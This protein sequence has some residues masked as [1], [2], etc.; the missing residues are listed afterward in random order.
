MTIVGLP[1]AR[2]HRPPRV[3]GV[4]VPQADS[5]LLIE[6][7]ERTCLAHR[8]SVLD[9]CTGSGVA[10]IAAAELGA[11]RVTAFDICSRA[12]RCARD[13]ARA[14]GV[15]I[16]VRQGPWDD[17][18]RYA[19]FDL[20]VANPPYVPSPRHGGPV[21]SAGGPEWSWNGGADGRL[22]LDPLCHSA[23]ALLGKGGSLLL[24]QSALAGVGQSLVALRAVGLT[25]QVAAVRHIPFGPVLSAHAGWLESTGQVPYGCRVEQLVVIRADK[26]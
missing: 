20:V 3:D 16:A 25:A 26:P 4:Y 5:Q 24:V 12:V 1:A 6:T 18:L 9:L 8:A 11:D 23:A 19:P 13:N 14:A 10:A 7:I 15:D 2:R 22:V 21:R 17:A